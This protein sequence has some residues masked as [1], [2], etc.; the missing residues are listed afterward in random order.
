MRFKCFHKEIICG[1]PSE[2]KPSPCD[3]DLAGTVRQRGWKVSRDWTPLMDTA[4]LAIALVFMRCDVTSYVAQLSCLNHQGRVCM[5]ALMAG[6]Q[7]SE[8]P[9][10]R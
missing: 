2:A 3:T 9:R 6:V 4:A 7:K 1:F 8:C 10:T 5:A